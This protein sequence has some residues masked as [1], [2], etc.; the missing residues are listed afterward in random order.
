M[1]SSTTAKRTST[2]QRRE[3]R[4]LRP[5]AAAPE[6][7]RIS[8]S[9]L[10]HLREIATQAAELQEQ[11]AK[12]QEQVNRHNFLVTGVYQ[13]LFSYYGLDP[14]HDAIGD[15]GAIVRGARPDLP[16]PDA[17]APTGE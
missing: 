15:D 2:V 7:E 11:V 8:P 6:A 3:P 16:V 4:P 1:A 12:L 10:A 5:V 14:E 9:E 13:H 17:A